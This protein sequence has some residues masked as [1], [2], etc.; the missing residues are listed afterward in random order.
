MLKYG[1][2]AGLGCVAWVSCIYYYEPR[3]L[4]EGYENINWLIILVAM[5]AASLAY[6]R[7]NQW[8]ATQELLKLNFQ[9]FAIAYGCKY[10]LILSLFYTDKNLIEMVKTIQLRYYLAQRDNNLPEQ[11]LNEQLAQF[12]QLQADTAIFD[13]LGLFIH[14]LMGFVLA[15]LLSFILKRDELE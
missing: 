3:W 1:A 11:V 6:L 2:T 9:T 7:Q 8:A 14:F 10:V 13:P 4:V 5:L 15:L 12:V